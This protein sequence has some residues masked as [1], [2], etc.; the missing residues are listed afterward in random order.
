MQ[1]VG[2]V[3][4]EVRPHVGRRLPGQLAQVLGQLLLAVAPG[5]V[6]VRLLETDLR[7]GVHHGRPGERLRQE[8]HVRVPA[9][10]LGDDP[11]PEHHRFGVGIVHPEDPHPVVH[12]VPQD[13]D[14]LRDQA[15]HVRVEGDGVDVLV[16]LGRVLGMGDGA[17][18]AVVEPLRVLVDPGVVRRA[19]QG[20]VQRHFQ[21]QL[22]GPVHEAVEVLDGAQA[23]VDGVVAALGGADRPGHADVAGAG[24]EGV[25]GALAEG[26]ADGVDRGEVDDVEAHRRDRLQPARGGAEGA[27]GLLGGALGT[28]E[29][30]V[31][32]AVQGAFPLHQQGQRIAGGHQLPQRVPGQH[33]PHLR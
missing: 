22:R 32:G 1:D 30:L 31:P 14:R 7:Q 5:E 15:V 6:R 8:D 16:L 20:E 4:E 33:R 24:G 9:V 10:G 13:P 11:F 29:E 18:R 21:A 28:R 3:G 19:L 17:V 2:G 25:V 26:R 23:G 27:V 12:P